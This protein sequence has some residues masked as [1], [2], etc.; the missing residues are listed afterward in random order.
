[1]LDDEH[2][3]FCKEIMGEYERGNLGELFVRKVIR[4]V[5]EDDVELLRGAFEVFIGVGFKSG[6]RVV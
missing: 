1:M 2:S 6:D 3:V 4:G 5:G